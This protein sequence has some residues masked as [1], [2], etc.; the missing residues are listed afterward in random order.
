VCF[1]IYRQ[2]F[3]LQ[4]LGVFRKSQTTIYITTSWCVSEFTLTAMDVCLIVM[5]T[6]IDLV[7]GF[8]PRLPPHW[9]TKTHSDITNAGS[10]QAISEYIFRQKMNATSPQSQAVRHTSTLSL[11]LESFLNRTPSNLK[12]HHISKNPS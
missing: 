4:R 5:I 3:E 2:Q 7:S 12:L 6:V 11:C 9:T 10:L 1:G 8:Y